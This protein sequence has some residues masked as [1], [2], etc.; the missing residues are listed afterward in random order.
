M[1]AWLIIETIAVS[2][3]QFYQIDVV[4]RRRRWRRGQAVWTHTFSHGSWLPLETS[5]AST[6][7]FTSQHL[8]Y[9]AA[10]PAETPLGQTEWKQTKKETNEDKWRNMKHRCNMKNHFTAPGS[11]KSNAYA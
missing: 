6:F 8:T 2:K 5:K 3:T 9:K 1:D 11:W 10:N 7:W 4:L